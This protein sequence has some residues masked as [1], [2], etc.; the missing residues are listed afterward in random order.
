MH[1]E[2]DTLTRSRICKERIVM[3][4]IKATWKN[5]LVILDRPGSWPEG[6][7]LLVSEDPGPEIE[8]MTE[9]E[10]RD[11]SES[12]QR[13]IDELRSIPPLPMTPEQEAAMLAWQQRVKEFNLEAVRKQMQEG[14][15]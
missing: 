8:F 9:E 2:T 3:G 13:W 7:R 12:V 6:H 11:D 10:Q 15:P 1:Q 4:V 5:G 14:V